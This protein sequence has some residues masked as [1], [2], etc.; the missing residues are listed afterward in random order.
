MMK[1]ITKITND[2]S[3]KNKEYNDKITS[4]LEKFSYLKIEPSN[5]FKKITTEEIKSINEKIEKNIKDKFASKKE[6]INEI[7]KKFLER[8]YPKHET[9]AS[10]IIQIISNQIK[11]KKKL[12]GER[13]EV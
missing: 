7:I 6:F 4:S 9:N 8:N 10:K 2:D 13:M 11:T 1:K 3:L 5:N 12:N